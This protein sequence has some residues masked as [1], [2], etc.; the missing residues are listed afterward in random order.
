MLVE[1]FVVLFVA[2]AIEEVAVDFAAAEVA[3]TAFQT[4]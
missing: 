4:S 2:E 3:S 1:L